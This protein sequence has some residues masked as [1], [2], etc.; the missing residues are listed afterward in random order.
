M[1]TM[2]QSTQLLTKLIEWQGRRTDAEFAALIGL[3]RSCWCR[4]RRGR[5]GLS[6]RHI[7]R[8]LAV[9][10]DLAPFYTADLMAPNGGDRAA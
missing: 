6:E 5:R 7:R 3:E 10:P 2:R 9:R 8:I 4:V 1:R